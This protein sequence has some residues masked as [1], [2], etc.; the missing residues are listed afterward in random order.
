MAIA[1]KGSTAN[2]VQANPLVISIATAADDYLLFAGASDSSASPA[3]PTYE[4]PFSQTAPAGFTSTSTVDGMRFH[5]AAGKETGTDSSKSIDNG[6]SGAQR[7]IGRIAAF[8]GVDLTTPFDATPVTASENSSAVAG[9]S[10]MAITTATPNA[11]LVLC[12]AIDATVTTD[13]TWTVS[14]GG[15]GLTWTAL[16][17]FQAG[18][19]CKGTILY[20]PKPSAGAITVSTTF[21]INAGYGAI[22]YALKPDTGG[23]G[24][25][26]IYGTPFSNPI[27]HTAVIR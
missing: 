5:A 13:P 24:G 3:T 11:W 18:G 22:L 1:L 17:F 10:G 4:S 25:G 9:T 15:A 2:I 19:F 12:L 26:S 6:A 21:G 27:F 7:L 23:G 14:D 8:T 16:N 20:A